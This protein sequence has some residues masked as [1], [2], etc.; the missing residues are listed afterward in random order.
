MVIALTG[1]TVVFVVLITLFIV[2]K[3][4]PQLI[5]RIMPNRLSEGEEDVKLEESVDTYA[6][7]T[8]AISAAVHLYLDERHDEEATVLTINQVKKNYSP[9]SSKI[10]GTHNNLVYHRR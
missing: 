10:Y 4:S 3:V 9:W 5:H 7:T 2:F 8:A 1:V 6:E